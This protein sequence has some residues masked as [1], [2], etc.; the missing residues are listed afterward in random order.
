MIST[1]FKPLR[2]RISNYARFFKTKPLKTK[3][4]SKKPQPTKKD[5]IV[6]KLARSNQDK[7]FNQ[8]VQLALPR[9]YEKIR[10]K[11]LSKIIFRLISRPLI[12]PYVYI[13][14][15]TCFMYPSDP[16]MVKIGL[17][18]FPDSFNLQNSTSQRN[19]LMEMISMENTEVEYSI[20]SSVYKNNGSN[21]ES[22]DDI[23]SVSYLWRIYF[24][25]SI[26]AVLSFSYLSFGWL[27]HF[28]KLNSVVSYQERIKLSSKRVLDSRVLRTVLILTGCFSWMISAIT[29]HTKHIL[30]IEIKEIIAKEPNDF[31]R[32]LMHCFGA[33]GVA[34]V[35][36]RKNENVEAARTIIEFHDKDERDNPK[37]WAPEVQSD[38]FLNDEKSLNRMFETVKAYLESN[39]A[40]I[41]PLEPNPI[42][43]Q[44]LYLK[45]ENQVGRNPYLEKITE[46]LTNS[47]VWRH[48]Q[49]ANYYFIHDTELNSNNFLSLLLARI[50]FPLWTMQ[51]HGNNKKRSYPCLCAND[52]NEPPT[53][54]KFLP[55][56]NVLS[57]IAE[58]SFYSVASHIPGWK[59]YIL[60]V[61]NFGTIVTGREST[62]FM[63]I[64]DYIHAH[65]NNK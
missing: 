14:C 46:T 33:Q 63:F 25:Q 52:P 11:N 5:N 13:V 4:G 43:N 64:A 44:M 60:P 56:R 34:M 57:A 49:M 61:A 58:Y 30:D 20:K 21:D 45:K 38:C 39:E 54:G 59:E 48:N 50:I 31:N 16:R 32:F 53:T 28:I 15:F 19:L 1:L 41:D 40:G 3:S 9:Q 2:I 10:N 24:T 6:T 12:W 65:E 47:L 36:L 26:G 29:F 62:I 8:T 18:R 7:T 27:Y 42:L 51:D 22:F 35:R 55:V 17:S 23:A 37:S